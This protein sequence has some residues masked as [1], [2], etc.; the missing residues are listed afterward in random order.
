[1]A[2]E[3]LRP[4]GTLD[5]EAIRQHLTDE[6]TGILDRHG[7]IRDHLQNVDRG[8]ETD[9]RDA[10][11]LI[12]ND[13]VLEV[14]EQNGREAIMGIVQALRRIDEGTYTVCSR[15]GGEIS[16]RRL[17]ALPTTTLCVRCAAE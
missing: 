7:K 9:W 2:T 17:A 5:I 8:R 10:A 16:P 15:C 14:L 1:M 4:D 3:L 6:L 11:Q 12:E 13:E